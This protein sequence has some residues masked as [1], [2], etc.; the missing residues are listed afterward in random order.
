M[1]EEVFIEKKRQTN[2]QSSAIFL[3]SFSPPFFLVMGLPLNLKCA[4]THTRRK[5]RRK[6]KTVYCVHVI[7]TGHAGK[8]SRNSQ[9]GDKS[10]GKPR[11]TNRRARWESRGP[12][13]SSGSDRVLTEQPGA[14]AENIRETSLS[15]TGL[16]R[17]DLNE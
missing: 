12:I 6:R 4:F 8:T 5:E 10:W 2:G 3:V 17:T 9:A 13:R 14:S 11:Q 16:F 1:V 7:Q 15:Q